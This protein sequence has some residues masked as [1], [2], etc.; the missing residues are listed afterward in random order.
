MI[1]AVEQ[2][3]KRLELYRYR[4]ATMSTAWHQIQ[5]A[6]VG[7]EE[8]G[9]WST[10]FRQPATWELPSF[11]FFLGSCPPSL[12]ADPQ[13]CG[14]WSCDESSEMLSRPPSY[15]IRF[16]PGRVSDSGSYGEKG[17]VWFVWPVS[18]GADS[19]HRH[20]RSDVRRRGP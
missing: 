4:M 10:P 12:P 1:E 19:S 16:H 3:A 5:A 15:P 20:L 8:N 17:Y 7:D 14:R 13:A 2:T 9:L 18:A 11:H 6:L